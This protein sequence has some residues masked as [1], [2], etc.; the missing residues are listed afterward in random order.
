MEAIV[1]IVLQVFFA[2]PI[3]LKIGNILGYY[4]VLAENIRSR[5]ALRPI[6]RERKYQWAA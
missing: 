6:A 4:P 1:F 5:D 2:T 3:V